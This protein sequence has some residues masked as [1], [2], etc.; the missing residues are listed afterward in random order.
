M[1]ERLTYA[2]LLALFASFFA[3]PI[4]AAEARKERS[5]GTFGAW[6]ALAYDEGIQ[7]VCYMVTAKIV[8]STDKKKNRKSYLMVT[9]R[10]IEASS[11]VFSY[12]A[13]EALDSKHDVTLQIGKD[14][15]DLFSVKE[16]AWA[17]DPMTDH[18][19]A[20]AIR[21]SSVAQIS[22][23]PAR[24]RATT[25]ADKFSLTG[26]L[27]AY[28]AINKAC[29]LPDIVLV[30]KELTKKSEVKKTET[31]KA[32]AKKP[33]AKKPALK[34]A[35]AQKTGAKIPELKKTTAVKTTATKK[36]TAR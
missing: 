19:I 31:K 11:D 33:E 35:A 4:G 36:K 1:K 23:I 5:L 34:K 21:S 17:R 2:V 29:G 32:A 22:A 12:G 20:T 27:S 13:G 10:P 3:A 18:K 15:F 16:T 30:K 9:H 25:I 28:R 24:G 8:K 14:A 6:H 26:A 7:T